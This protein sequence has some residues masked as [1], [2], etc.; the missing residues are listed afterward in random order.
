[1]HYL[2]CILQKVYHE[3]RNDLLTRYSAL[4]LERIWTAERFS[5]WMTLLLHRLSD[6]RFDDRMRRAEFDYFTSTEEGQR[7]IARNY[8]GL[9][10]LEI[11]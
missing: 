1:V 10:L 6:N 2:R 5:W 8:V 7:S 4:A 9:P 3:G 11:E